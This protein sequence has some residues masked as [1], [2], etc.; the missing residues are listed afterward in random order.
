MRLFLALLVASLVALSGCG[1][2]DNDSKQSTQANGGGASTQ[3][4]PSTSTATTPG[5]TTKTEAE[6][7]SAD[8]GGSDASGGSSAP[9][10]SDDQGGGSGGSGGASGNAGGGGGEQQAVTTAVTGFYAALG[11]G[12]GKQACALMSDSIK[13]AFTKA[14]SQ[15]QNQQGASCETLAKSVTK[16][17]P[18]GLRQRL[19]KL[20]L[21]KV[22]IKGDNAKV[23]VTLPGVPPSTLPLVRDDGNWKIEAPVG[24][25]SGSTPSG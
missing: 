4:A 6:Q 3:T 17:Y 18:A 20:K 16:A 1:G 25:N 2:D 9:S 23:T 14:L 21:T 5:E 24:A 22:T 11:S 12:D 8:N 7:D 10:P 15:A 13:K 19:A